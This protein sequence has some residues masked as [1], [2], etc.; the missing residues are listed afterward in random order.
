MK[1]IPNNKDIYSN[2]L[3]RSNYLAF[4]LFEDRL[5]GQMKINDHDAKNCNLALNNAPDSGMERPL[6]IFLYQKS[7]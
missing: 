7:V 4:T 5:F 2:H 1:N 6:M 3:E